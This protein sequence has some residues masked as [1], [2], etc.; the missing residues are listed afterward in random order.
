MICNILALIT[1][2]AGTYYVYIETKNLMKS[3]SALSEQYDRLKAIKW[4]RLINCVAIPGVIWMWI[5][6]IS[7]FIIWITI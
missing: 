4:V 1:T 2:I 3:I 6:T 5:I 7:S